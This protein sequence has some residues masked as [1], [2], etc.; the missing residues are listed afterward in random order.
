VGL[1]PEVN[2]EFKKKK[3]KLLCVK[4]LQVSRSSRVPA[5]QEFLHIYHCKLK[6]N[7]NHAGDQV[8][9]VKGI[10]SLCQVLAGF[11]G[12]IFPGSAYEKGHVTPMRARKEDKEA[13]ELGIDTVPMIVGPVSYLLL[14]KLAKGVAK[15]LN[16]HS[17]LDAILPIYKQVVSELEA[18]GVTFVHS[19]DLEAYQLEAFSKVYFYLDATSLGVNLLVEIYFADIPVQTYKT[20]TGLKGISAIGFDLIR[21]TKTLGL[22]KEVGFPTDKILFAGVVDGRNIWANDLA[23]SLSVLESL[24]NIV[25]KDK[26]VVSTSCSLLHTA[27]DLENE[28]KLDSEIKSWLAY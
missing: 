11:G 20:I 25:G 21:G 6:S 22:I 4:C 16:L 24:K 17:L 8:T 3:K 26:L 2:S 23:D 13:K 1:F 18:A 10:D 12:A 14:S 28:T 19:M 15:T 27:V 5:C 7:T 9:G